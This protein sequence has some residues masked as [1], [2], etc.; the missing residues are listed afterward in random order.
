MAARW[1]RLREQEF[2]WLWIIATA[3]YGVGDTVTTIAIVQFSPTVRE[4]NVLVR[5]VVETF[6]NGG[7]AGLKIAVLLFCIGLSLAALR[8]TED[9]ISYYAPPVVLAVVGAFTTV[10]NLRLLLG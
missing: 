2:Y 5:A 9:R 4:A 1:T 3:T 6:G 10:Y 8:G 7:L